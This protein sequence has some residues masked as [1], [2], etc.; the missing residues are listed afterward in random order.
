ML[1]INNVSKVYRG[2]KKAVNKLNMTIEKG[3]FIAFIGTSGSGKTTAMRMI[4]RMIEPT[5][6]S[7]VLNGKNI[8]DMNPVQLHGYDKTP[9]TDNGRT[10][11]K[12]I[13]YYCRYSYSACYRNRCNSNRFIYR[14]TE[15]W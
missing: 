13:C 2:G 5:S 1:E 8:K 10:A 9:V 11:I 7:I 6:G 15:S 3:E 12:S 14:C 4:N